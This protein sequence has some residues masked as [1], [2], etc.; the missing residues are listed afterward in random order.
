MYLLQE[1]KRQLICQL[2]AD[3]TNHV[4]ALHNYNSRRMAQKTI[5]DR[6]ALKKLF[7]VLGPRY[8]VCAYTC[9]HDQLFIVGQENACLANARTSPTTQ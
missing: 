9:A 3:K 5:Q 6:G 8:K 4:C 2:F 1:C 7:D